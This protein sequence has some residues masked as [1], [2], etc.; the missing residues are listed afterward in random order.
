MELR[1]VVKVGRS[2]AKDYL[3]GGKNSDRGVSYL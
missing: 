1:T 2:P 3:S